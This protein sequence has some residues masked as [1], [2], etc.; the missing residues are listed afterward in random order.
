MIQ[1]LS[2]GAVALVLLYGGALALVLALVLLVLYRLTIGRLMRGV[3][4][5]GP[6]EHWED[7]PRLSPPLPLACTVDTESG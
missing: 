5:V 2:Q 1:L 3:P 6:G 4:S 7:G